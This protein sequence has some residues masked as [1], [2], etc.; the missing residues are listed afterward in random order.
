VGSNPTLSANQAESTAGE[1][2]MALMIGFALALAVAIFARIV[3]LDRERAF[4]STVLIV[5]GSYY[6][7]FAAMA[8][9]AGG[10]RL[11]ILFF[12]AF[13]GAAALGFRTSMWVVASGLAL[14]G[15]FDFVRVGS[16]PAPGA[17]EWWPGFCG[18]FD[19]AAAAVLALLILSGKAGA[20]P[21][22]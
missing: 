22:V 20:A 15:A 8:G 7:L 3:G 6:V 13:A 16:L 5:V 2:F 21:R 12:L 11:E 10:I 19:V 17:P 1:Q 18:G 9:S 14:H 4:Y